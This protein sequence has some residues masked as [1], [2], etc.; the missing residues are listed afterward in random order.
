MARVSL[1]SVCSGGGGAVFWG[2]GRGG[3]CVC[4]GEGAIYVYIG[5]FVCIEVLVC[6]GRI[7]CTFVYVCIGVCV[8]IWDVPL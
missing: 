6:G 2:V 7:R 3:V 5:L 4:E 8:G 1:A